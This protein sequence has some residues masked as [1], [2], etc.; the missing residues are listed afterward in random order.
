MPALGGESRAGGSEGGSNNITN[1]L[2]FEYVNTA[3]F[4]W[5]CVNMTP[6]RGAIWVFHARETIDVPHLNNAGA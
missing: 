3:F 6:A 4:T 2:R 1:F 5:L